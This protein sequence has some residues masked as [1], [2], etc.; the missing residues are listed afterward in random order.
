VTIPARRPRP[1][2][3]YSAIDRAAEQ[4]AEQLPVLAVEAAH[5]NLLDRR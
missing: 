4:F 3:P 1:I 5:L 2:R